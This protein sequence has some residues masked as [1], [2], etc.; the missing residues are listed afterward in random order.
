MALRSAAAVGRAVEPIPADMDVS[1]FTV[2][3]VLQI[4]QDLQ[5]L[6]ESGAAITLY[7]PGQVSYV[8]GRLGEVD[9]AAGKIVFDP[10]GEPIVPTGEQLFVALQGGT[11]YQFVTAWQP[12]APGMSARRMA[13]PL[14]QRLVKL[15][16]R[17]HMRQNAPIGLPFQADFGFAGRA[18]SLSVVDLSP[19]GVGLRAS[20]KEAGRLVIGRRLPQVRLWLGDG[21]A[22]EVDLEIRSRFLWRTYLLGEQ[23][24]I[25]CSFPAL[26]ADDEAVLQAALARLNRSMGAAAE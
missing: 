18:Y 15:Q 20:P 25:G 12:E 1:P 14:P 5:R 11:K 17:R 16:R 23:Y 8:L 19:G 24:L 26:G 21:I 2:L 6:A 13:M 4:T 22:I 10:V 3:D 7:P 9:G